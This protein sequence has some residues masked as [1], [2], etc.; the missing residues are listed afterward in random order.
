MNKYQEYIAL[1]GEVVW[2]LCGSA[3]LITILFIWVKL[4]TGGK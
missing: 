1:I 3:C 2:I 4:A